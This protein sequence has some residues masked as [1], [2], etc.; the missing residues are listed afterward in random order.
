MSDASESKVLRIG[1]IQNGLMLEE[2]VF[3]PRSTVTV[4]S[5]EGCSFRLALPGL[6][7]PFAMFKP[8]DGA[9]E[10][11][12]R[13]PLSGT[14]SLA[15]GQ[16]EAA[17]LPHGEL[18]ALRATAS[19]SP[20]GTFALRLS[21]RHKGKVRIGDAFLLFHFIAQ[22][23]RLLDDPT[24][25]GDPSEPTLEVA[26]RPQWWSTVEFQNEAQRVVYDRVRTFMEQQW[27]RFGSHPAQPYFALDRGSARTVVRVDPWHEHDAIVRVISWVVTGA[28]TSDP[29]LLRFLLELNH[30]AQFGAFGI[31]P[32]GDIFF[33]H[34]MVGST[35]DR[36]EL[37]ASVES[38]LEIADRYD[39]E[40][41]SRWGGMRALDA[42]VA[43]EPTM[44]E[45]HVPLRKFSRLHVG[46]DGVDLSVRGLPIAVAALLEMFAA[47][48]TDAD[49]Q[50]AFPALEPE[51]LVQ[52]H[53]YGV[54]VEAAADR[55][56]G[57]S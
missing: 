3:A 52:V 44:D 45:D 46:P 26:V 50:A 5:A 53:E 7:E 32:E 19:C 34:S 41:Q 23:A 15:S 9:Y 42:L 54:Y 35:L 18:D 40:I 27:G 2:R 36:E 11:R 48:K 39:D 1:I 49:V 57:A 24:F 16:A 8:V 6:A 55:L 12:W 22:P 29:S 21:P 51:D 13:E 56:L 10:L 17:A 38:V 31:D 14:V 30:S 25:P 28:D 47:G 33:T 37:A 20:D 43:D 4:G